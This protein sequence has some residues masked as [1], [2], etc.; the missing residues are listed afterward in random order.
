MIEFLMLGVIAGL[1]ATIATEILLAVLQ[2]QAFNMQAS[3]HWEIWWMGPV[4]GGVFV[5]VVGLL[6]T[7]KLLTRNTSEMLRSVNL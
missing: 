3:V 5:A 6:S 4:I 2:T 7:V 1:M